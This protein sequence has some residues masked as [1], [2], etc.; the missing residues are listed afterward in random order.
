MSSIGRTLKRFFSRISI[1]ADS[2]WW[3]GRNLGLWNK[4]DVHFNLISQ[5]AL[6]LLTAHISIQFMGNLP[7]EYWIGPTLKEGFLSS[8]W[9]SFQ[10]ASCAC[11]HEQEK[12]IWKPLWKVQCQCSLGEWR[13]GDIGWQSNCNNT[14]TYIAEFLVLSYNWKLLNLLWNILARVKFNF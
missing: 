12:L 8:W 10:N 2:P 14:S 9:L 6:P 13:P 1:Y 11:V 7:L 5:N 4:P 3:P